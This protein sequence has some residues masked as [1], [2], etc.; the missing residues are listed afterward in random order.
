MRAVVSK[1]RL[2]KGSIAQDQCPGSSCGSG[3]AWLEPDTG[4]SKVNSL[5]A[6]NILPH[7]LPFWLAEARF[8]FY[9]GLGLSPSFHLG[10]ISR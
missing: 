6:R 3:E 7:L 10:P 2:Y 4:I 1:R 8:S 9:P 5:F